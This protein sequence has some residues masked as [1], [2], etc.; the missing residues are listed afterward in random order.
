MCRFKF[1]SF[2]IMCWYM[3]W[4]PPYFTV[5]KRA[6]NSLFKFLV[7]DLEF[8][9]PSNECLS[10]LG[11]FRWGF[12]QLKLNPAVQL[13]ILERMTVMVTEVHVH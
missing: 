1:L 10:E 3:K 12:L 6:I 7:C 5:R 4:P 8:I 9:P 11:F 2:E 13:I